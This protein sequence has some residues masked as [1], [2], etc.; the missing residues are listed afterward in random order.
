[1]VFSPVA[2]ELG[3]EGAPLAWILLEEGLESQVVP[4]R[5][6]PGYGRVVP[7]VTV[8]FRGQVKPPTSLKWV[9]VFR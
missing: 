2:V 9:V 4:S 7:A 5:Y 8:E 1:L 6:S 3:P